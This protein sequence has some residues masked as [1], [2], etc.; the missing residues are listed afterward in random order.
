MVSFSATGNPGLG[1]HARCGSDTPAT[2]PLTPPTALS[3]APWC[4]TAA[5]TCSPQGPTSRSWRPA[6]PPSSRSSGLGGG[7][8]P[9]RLFGC[10]V[11]PRSVGCSARATSG[12]TGWGLPRTATTE[13]QSAGTGQPTPVRPYVEASGVRRLRREERRGIRD[14]YPCGGSGR[15]R[16]ASANQPLLGAGGCGGGNGCGSSGCHGHSTCARVAASTI[17][18][19]STVF[20]S[21]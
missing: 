4:S 11:G 6:A 12:M 15:R 20:G 17:S 14:R 9:S 10:G 13:R 19:P 7:L 21:R 2:A 5:N 3:S 18:A 16:T 1:L 8:A